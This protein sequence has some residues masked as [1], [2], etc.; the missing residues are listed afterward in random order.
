[1]TVILIIRAQ[2]MAKRSQQAIW[3]LQKTQQGMALEQRRRH[4]QSQFLNMLMHELKTPLS[5]VSLALGTQANREEKLALASQA[6]KD[7]KAIIDRC[8][9]ADQ[10]G[11]LTLRQRHQSVS[12]PNVIQELRSQIPQLEHRFNLVCSSPLPQALVDLQLLQI[13]LNNLLD[14][15][16]R[17]GDPLADV[18]VRVERAC[19]E[20]RDGLCIRVINLPG[21]AGWPRADRLFEKYYRADNARSQSGSGLGLHLSRELAKIL[22]ANLS[23]QPSAE[24]VEFVLWIPLLPD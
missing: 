24:H 15:A 8:V 21:K 19:Q 13:I 16:A 20:G 7:I 23:Y 17:Y 11:Q 3:D 18:T 9:S 5:V 22:Q 2:R 14:N 4:E 1:M 12:L 10:E 6:V